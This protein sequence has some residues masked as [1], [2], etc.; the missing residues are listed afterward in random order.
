MKQTQICFVSGTSLVLF[1]F[2]ISPA[3]GQI[4]VGTTPSVAAERSAVCRGVLRGTC[5]RLNNIG[6]SPRALSCRNCN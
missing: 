1:L 3:W 4:N 5:P 6:I 2:L